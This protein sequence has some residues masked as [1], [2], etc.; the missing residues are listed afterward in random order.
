MQTVLIDTDVAIDWLRGEEYT[1]GFLA[2]LLR[3]NLARVSV[4]TAYELYAGMRPSEQEPVRLFL[5]SC[6]IEDVTSE[7]AEAAGE[8]FR[9]Y[10]KKGVAL[11][12]MDCLIMATG[13]ARGCKIATRN[14]RHFPDETLLLW[15]NPPAA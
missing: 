6:C 1:K 9:H 4:L 13:K 10:R 2:P 8:Y 12:G 3:A 15:K 5:E 7:I 11:T 14:I